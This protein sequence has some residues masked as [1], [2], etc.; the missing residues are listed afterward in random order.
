ML[1]SGPAI[2][3]QK[4]P[5]LAKKIIFSGEAHEAAILFSEKCYSKKSHTIEHL[6]FNIHDAIAKIRPHTLEK[7]HEN[8]ADRMRRCE[9]HPGSHIKE[10][11]FH[12]KTKTIAL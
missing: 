9:D 8:C 7:V 12:F 1:R 11:I 4:M 2:D 6:K 10:I 3:L 5:I